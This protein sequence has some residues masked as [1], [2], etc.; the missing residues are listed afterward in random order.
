MR[1]YESAKKEE[2]RKE[3]L[4]MLDDTAEILRTKQEAS[5]WA[6][7]EDHIFGMFRK[8]GAY[9]KQIIIP[10]LRKNEL[11]KVRRGIFEIGVLF[12]DRDISGLMDLAN[13]IGKTE[14]PT[15]ERRVPSLSD[16]RA[17]PW[18]R[19]AMLVGVSSLIDVV[20]FYVILILQSQPLINYAPWMFTAWLA[21]F[22]TAS[23][24]MTFRR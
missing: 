12:K 15:R 9:V 16:L 11:D 13:G 5:G 20:G 23:V 14:V 2:D 22:V 3:C 18:F 7:V 24:A 1:S 21:A 6:L 4:Q 8:L 10:L 17:R 19:F